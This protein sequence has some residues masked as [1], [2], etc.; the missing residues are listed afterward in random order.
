[1]FIQFSSDVNRK[2]ATLVYYKKFDA[3][4][5]NIELPI[6]FRWLNRIHQIDKTGV[7]KYDELDKKLLKH[8][9][10]ALKP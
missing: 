7:I 3:E 9:L 6:P 10:V 8:D 5:N 4:G 2:K 1:M